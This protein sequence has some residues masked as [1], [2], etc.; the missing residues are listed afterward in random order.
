MNTPSP[1]QP[2]PPS[3]VTV[4]VPAQAPP[5]T[6]ALEHASVLSPFATP[7]SVAGLLCIGGGFAAL[8]FG[9]C[10]WTDLEA[11]LPIIFGIMGGTGAATEI[12]RRM[13]LGRVLSK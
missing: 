11:F 6:S 4:N 5:D 1:V 12:A 3:S 13:A 9:K 8:L 7:I 10:A 2:A